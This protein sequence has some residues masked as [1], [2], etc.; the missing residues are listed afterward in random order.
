MLNFGSFNNHGNDTG[1]LEYL[2]LHKELKKHSHL[3]IGFILRFA[4]LSLSI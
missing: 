2:Y 4:N 1:P 3:Q